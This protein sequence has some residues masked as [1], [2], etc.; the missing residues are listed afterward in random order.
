LVCLPEGTKLYTAN[1]WQAVL[2]RTSLSYFGKFL[3][4]GTPGESVSIPSPG[5]SSQVLPKQ[6]RYGLV[7]VVL[8]R[9]LSDLRF[10]GN[11]FERVFYVK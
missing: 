10:Q 4:E 9:T 2:E 11:Y 6:A 3:Q 5:C 7:A 1:S 8:E